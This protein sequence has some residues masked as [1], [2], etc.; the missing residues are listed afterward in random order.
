MDPSGATDSITVMIEVTDV[1]EGATVR[2]STAPE[3]DGETDERSVDE[4][5]AAGTAVGDPVVATD[6]DTGDSLTYSLDEMGDMH[7]DIDDMGQITVG[8]GTMLDFESGMTSY[9]VTVMA[10]DTARL[11]DTIMVTITVVDVNEAPTFDAETAERSVAENT[12]A[13]ENIGAPVAAM[14]VDADDTLTYSLDEMGDMYFDIDDMGQI[15]VGDGTMLDFETMASHTVTVTATDAAGLYAMIAVTITVVDV[16]E[17]P[18]FDAETAERSVAENTAAGENIGAPVAAMDVDADDTLTYSL[19]EMGD[20]YFDIDDMGQITVGDGTMLDFETMASHTVTVTA[21]DAAGLY[22]M[23]AVTITV[24]DVNEAPT[25]DAETAERSVAENTAAGENIGAPVAAMDVDADD[26]LTYS[27]DEMGDMYFDIDDMGQIT[28]GDGTMLDFETMASHTV[29]VTA[30][31]AAGLYAMIAVTITVTDVNEAPTFDAE[32][33]ERR[34]GREHGSGRWNIGDPV[35]AMDVD[36]GDTLTYSLDATGDMSFDIDSATGQLM[37]EAALDY[38]MTTSYSVTVTATDSGGLYAM[39]AVTIAVNDVPETPIFEANAV[40]FP[41]DENMPVGTEVG[42]VT[43][44]NAESYSDDLDYFDVDDMG[45]ITTTMMFDYEGADTSFMGTV[46]A[47]GVDGTTDS[48]DGDGDG[49]GRGRVRGRRSDGGGRQD[50]RRS[51][52]RL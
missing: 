23:I 42:T 3:F 16:N 41:V 32:T 5:S 27:L 2:L 40:E 15:T 12:A 48:I 24:T 13:G 22:A 8:E 52:G 25:F 35:A 10:T 33:A 37:T 18:T 50:E 43:A 21:T 46:T 7:F 19:D 47:T 9:T 28:V 36:A 51:D 1:D 49:Q 26:T 45:N 44:I 29:T 4:N 31:D 20:M 11:Y 14:D 38:E 30:T 6:G 39:I 17:A 34:R